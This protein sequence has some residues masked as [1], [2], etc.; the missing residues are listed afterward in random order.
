MNITSNFNKLFLGNKCALNLA[1]SHT[2]K[3]K[4][5]NMIFVC[6]FSKIALIFS[7]PFSLSLKMFC[8]SLYLFSCDLLWQNSNDD[9]VEKKSYLFFCTFILLYIFLHT[10]VM[11]FGAKEKR[12]EMLRANSDHNKSDIVGECVSLW[13][14]IID[15]GAFFSCLLRRNC[16]KQQHSYTNRS[17][18]NRSFNEMCGFSCWFR[19]F[20][21]A[22]S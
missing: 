10:F 5:G 20:I 18:D 19:V 13:I 11:H 16:N 15:R 21:S 3:Q 4:A 2:H 6:G 14:V 12:N 1:L 8:L 9:D 17:E 22:K 7:L